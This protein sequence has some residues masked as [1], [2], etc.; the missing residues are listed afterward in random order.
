MPSVWLHKETLSYIQY[1]QGASRTSFRRVAFLW[2][3]PSSDPAAHCLCTKGKI[4]TG[5]VLIQ[6]PI[7]KNWLTKELARNSTTTETVS[8]MGTL[9]I[10]GQSMTDLKFTTEL[11]K[12]DS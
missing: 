5:V 7:V 9:W 11:R 12:V 3:N 2:E 6:V 1:S 4:W 8:P 10:R